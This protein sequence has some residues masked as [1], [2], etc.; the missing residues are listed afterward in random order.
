MDKAHI[1]EEELS[2]DGANHKL[3]F[4]KLL[5]IRNM[6]MRCL[7]FTNFINSSIS[8]NFD[9]DIFQF[10]CVN[11]FKLKSQTLL[12]NILRFDLHQSSTEITLIVRINILESELS[13][14]RLETTEV[15]EAWSS[16]VLVV[17]LQVLWVSVD[18]SLEFSFVKF[19]LVS[20]SIDTGFGSGCSN[21]FFDNSTDNIGV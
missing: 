21:Q 13:E 9:F 12:R 4:P 14:L 18:G 15:P 20:K 1:S 7:T 16:V 5:V 8:L 6:E 17:T 3:G 11:L 19:E 10:F 2:F